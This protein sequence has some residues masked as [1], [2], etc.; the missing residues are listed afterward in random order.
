MKELINNYII[1]DKKYI[2]LIIKL[3]E[4]KKELVVI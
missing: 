4:I 3:V 2:I 1:I